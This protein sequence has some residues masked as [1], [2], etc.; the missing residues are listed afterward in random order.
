MKRYKIRD[1]KAVKKCLRAFNGYYALV[2]EFIEK[3]SLKSS[4]DRGAFTHPTQ[5]LNQEIIDLLGPSRHKISLGYGPEAGEDSLRNNIAELDNIKFGTHY[6]IENV[7]MVAGAWCGV[8]IVIEE[9]ANLESGQIKKLKVAVIGPTHY[10]LF[11]RPIEVLGVEVVGF[12]FVNFQGSTPQTWSEIEDILAIKPDAI[13]ITN[14]NNPNGEYFPPDLLKTLI[15][16]CKQKNIYIIIDEMQDFLQRKGKSIGYGKWIQSNNVIRINSYS[17]H[18]ALAEYRIGWVIANN[19]IVGDRYS[20]LIS[21]IR[22][23]MGNP[24]KASNDAILALL[25]IEKV[26]YQGG[27]YALEE[28]TNI[29]YE[30]EKYLREELQ[31]IPNIEILGTDA[32]F[33]ITI[34]ILN[35]SSDIDVA[36]KLMAAGTMI[37][38]CEGY[39]YDTKDSVMRITF[40]ERR[41]RIEHCLET[42]KSVVNNINNKPHE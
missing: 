18:Y 11:Q 15:N 12:D 24:P 20:G 25:Q 2:R 9:L 19:K 35:A 38:P 32:C 31:K 40:A 17:K 14:P 27:T 7:V 30:S 29:L 23:L 33:N 21:R 22:G 16:V 3:G 34:R 41:E 1:T 37:M 39:G 26:R 6:K 4:L 13:F 36:R 8:E 42:L 5:I 28:F 10:Q